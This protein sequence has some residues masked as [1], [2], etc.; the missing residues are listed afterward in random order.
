MGGVNR[1]LGVSLHQEWGK[2]SDSWNRAKE[3]GEMRHL[4][5]MSTFDAPKT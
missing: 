2:I 5:Y 3:S 1:R 4:L